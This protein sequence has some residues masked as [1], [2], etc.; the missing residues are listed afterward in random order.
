PAVA[1][2]LA[3]ANANSYFGS[4]VIVQSAAVLGSFACGVDQG[5]HAVLDTGAFSHLIR[6]L[7]AADE[8]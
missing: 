5:V 2:A 7:L 6:L 3:K 8:K 1:D 4:N